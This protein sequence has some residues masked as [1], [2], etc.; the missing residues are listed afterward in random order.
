MFGTNPLFYVVKK[1]NQVL[2]VGRLNEIFVLTSSSDTKEEVLVAG[3][4]LKCR[5][6]KKGVKGLFCCR[7]QNSQEGQLYFK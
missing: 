1:I 3:S 4:Q 2:V 6:A 7:Q 5:D